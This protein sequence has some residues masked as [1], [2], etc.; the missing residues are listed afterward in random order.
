MRDKLAVCTTAG[1][2][3]IL[4]II[5]SV[6]DI[7]IANKI[8]NEQNLKSL[9]Y[10]AAALQF[11]A[12]ISIAYFTFIF[13]GQKKGS[14][15]RRPWV[16]PAVGA[17][18][19]TIALIVTGV[20]IICFTSRYGNGLA[21]DFRLSAIGLTAWTISVLLHGAFFVLL[22][23]KTRKL[24]NMTVPKVLVTKGTGHASQKELVMDAGSYYSKDT[25]LA[26]RSCTPTS[27]RTY[28]LHSSTTRAS[29]RSKFARHSA[30]S[31][32]DIPAVPVADASVLST[33]FDRYDTSNIDSDVRKTVM[34][35][36]PPVTRSGLETI[37]G[38]RP[39]SPGD[40]LNNEV[41][42]P[43]SPKIQHQALATPEKA[44]S[45]T[46][47]N[48][49]TPPNSKS[50][51]N[52]SRPTSR[53]K[54]QPTMS[55]SGTPHPMRSPRPAASMTDLIHPLFRPDS[56]SPPLI[57]TS[58]TMVTASPLANQPIT[59]KTLSRLRSSSDLHRK[60]S[61]FNIPAIPNKLISSATTLSSPST[62]STGQWRVMPPIESPPP[63]GLRQRSKSHASIIQ[64][65]NST[66]GSTAVSISNSESRDE[67]DAATPLASPRR[68]ADGD[69]MIIGSPGPSIIE[70]DE[71]PPILPGFVLSAGSRMSLVG[72]GKRKSVKKDRDSVA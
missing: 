41:I 11:V 45:G 63:S 65:P 10:A 72:Y 24:S 40:T 13:V 52:F 60:P 35:S 18:F 71:L 12:L 27:P 4:T 25:T 55:G 5:S 8:D 70:E 48:N 9:L 6:L 57:L 3:A 62:P 17:G 68:T 32:L 44:K 1:I 49:T 19:D 46:S 34:S 58:G 30:K 43:T 69:T 64:R 59:P 67:F 37:P 33:A 23:M 51:P 28:S 22:A 31:S 61:Q 39:N 14:E 38:S 47:S 29:V 36:T 42:L 54:H 15:V 50:P 66:A 53:N 26:S 7:I 2:A 20:G 16:D 21:E 56:P